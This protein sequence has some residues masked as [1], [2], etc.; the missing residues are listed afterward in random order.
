[1][2][3]KLGHYPDHRRV[4]PVAECMVQRSVRLIAAEAAK[5]SVRRR[6]TRAGHCV[7]QAVP[8]GKGSLEAITDGSSRNPEIAEKIHDSGKRCNHPHKPEV[9]DRVAGLVL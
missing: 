1:V 5:Q 4:R 7:R 3:V 2:E 6:V 9:L 8:K